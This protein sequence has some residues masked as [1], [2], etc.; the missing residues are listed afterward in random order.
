MEEEDK[1]LAAAL[2]SLCFCLLYHDPQVVDNV[3]GGL[4]SV[5]NEYHHLMCSRTKEGVKELLHTALGLDSC[6][7]VQYQ[8]LGVL[9]HKLFK[10]V[11]QLLSLLTPLILHTLLIL[12]I[13]HTL[14]ILLRNDRA[15]VVLWKLVED[16]GRASVAEQFGGTQVS[17]PGGV[18]NNYSNTE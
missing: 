15:G 13:L 8:L 7:L 6:K 17:V 16:W 11:D 9:Q 3:L 10:E 5:D 12:L 18:V 1:Q 2:R 4:L 14:L